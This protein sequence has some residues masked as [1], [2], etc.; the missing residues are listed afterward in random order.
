MNCAMKLLTRVSSIWMQW[1]STISVPFNCGINKCLKYKTY[2]IISLHGSVPTR[3]DVETLWLTSD[4]RS[5]EV[6]S[7]F[8]S[9]RTKWD[10]WPDEEYSMPFKTFY[11]LNACRMF[12]HQTEFHEKFQSVWSRTHLF[13]GSINPFLLFE[14]NCKTKYNLRVCCFLLW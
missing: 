6:D 4:Q 8:I 2:P 3:A 10:K 1:H 12:L 7:D 14:N 5:F 13:C 11:S 9:G